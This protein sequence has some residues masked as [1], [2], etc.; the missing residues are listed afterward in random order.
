[1]RFSGLLQELVDELPMLRSALTQCYPRVH[2][3]VTRRMVEAVWPYRNEFITP[4]AAVAGAVAEAVLHAMTENRKLFR[5]YVNN[6]GDIAFHLVGGEQFRIGIAEI[7]D[8]SLQ[9][10]GVIDANMHVRGVATSGWRGRSFSFGIADSVTVL[11]A[12][13]AEADVA[14]TMIANAVN[15]DHPSIRRV[16]A[17]SLH[18]ESDLGAMLVTRN[19]PALD[20]SCIAAAL[21]SG[22]AKAQQY[23]NRGLFYSAVIRLQGHS[24]S[25]AASDTI[26]HR[27]ITWATMRSA[28]GMM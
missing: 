9:G 18:T 11:A 17:N 23:L 27:Q 3:P 22:V 15:V 26:P 6:G 13:A 7:D 24:R 16:A 14:A 8:G 2:G 28:I 4:M 5:A 21:N 25:V 1:M 20:E 10:V 19:V 12:T